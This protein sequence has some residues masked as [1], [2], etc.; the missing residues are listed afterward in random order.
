MNSGKRTI[1]LIFGYGAVGIIALIAV[2]LIFGISGNLMY[3]GSNA[4]ISSESVQSTQEF[5]SIDISKFSG[6]IKFEIGDE[7]AVS[8]QNVSDKFVCENENGTLKI[9]G[10][11]VGDFMHNRFGRNRNPRLTITMPRGAQTDR[12]EIDLGAGDLNIELLDAQEFILNAGAGDVY[13]DELFAEK[14]QING[15]VGEV[16]INGGTIRDCS[17]SSGVGDVE[18]SAELLGRCDVSNGVGSTDLNLP[19]SADDYYI[20]IEKGLGSVEIDDREVGKG[21]YGSSSAENSLKLSTGVGEI[22]VDFLK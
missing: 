1:A 6:T 18:I 8:A 7:F 13:I 12:V 15:G 4:H 10:Q 21:S 19:L 9:G 22:S 5:S 14:C 2:S 17:V 20:T 11:S 16:Q 3:S